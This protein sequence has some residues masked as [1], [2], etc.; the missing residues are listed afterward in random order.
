MLI[1]PQESGKKLNRV[2][3]WET[4]KQKGNSVGTNLCVK[5]YVIT[6]PYI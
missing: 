5:S 4:R 3:A 1:L 2:S 6:Q